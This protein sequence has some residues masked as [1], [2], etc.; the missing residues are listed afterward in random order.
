MDLKLVIFDL[1][2]TLVDAYTAVQKSFNVALEALG[3]PALDLDTVRQS[4]GWGE[5]LLIAKFVKEEDV[6][7]AISIYRQHHAVAL[8]SDVR[9]L[10]HA[11][12][13]LAALKKE[14]TQLAI[15][16]NRPARFTEIILKYQGIRSFFDYA[17][18][19]DQVKT[20]KP[21]PEILQKILQK[22][23]CL[24]QDAVYVGDMIVDVRAGA[25]ARIKT[26]AV[27]TGSSSKEEILAETPFACFDSLAEV[28]NVLLKR[29][30]IN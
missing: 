27:T 22:F 20:P 7:K 6:D 29:R 5:R 11:K 14:G 3:Y 25:N 30:K 15:A 1:D 17:L 28:G 10:P 24:S 26:I 4:V 19:A 13:V 18:C 23:G 9:L 2:G 21:D 8:K 16:S 12:E